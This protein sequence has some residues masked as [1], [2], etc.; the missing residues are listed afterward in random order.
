MEKLDAGKLDFE[1]TSKGKVHGNLLLKY[2]LGGGNF[3][4]AF[5]VMLLYLLSQTAAS[6]ADFWVSYW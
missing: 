2:M 3:C 1:E 4:F 6:G 5:T